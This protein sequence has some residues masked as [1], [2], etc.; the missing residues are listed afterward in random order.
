MSYRSLLQLLFWLVAGLRGAAQTY[1]ASF[2]SVADT[3]TS[4]L[5]PTSPV[6]TKTDMSTKVV[7]A[8]PADIQRLFISFNFVYHATSNPS[9]IPANA[10]IF[11]AKLVLTPI[12]DNP[13]AT[14]IAERV[15]NSWTQTTLTHNIAAGF[16]YV[17]EAGSSVISGRRTFDLTNQIQA[18]VAGTIPNYGWRIRHKTE[19]AITPVCTYHTLESTSGSTFFPK[20]EIQWYIPAQITQVVIDPASTTTATDGNILVQ[21]ENSSGT[22]AYQW[23]NGSAASVTGGTAGSA[24][25]GATSPKLS[26]VSYG[27][28][29]L[30][31]TDALGET[32]YTAFLL[33]VD[34]QQV[35]INFNPG[36]DYIDD[37]VLNSS[38]PAV[39]FGSNVQLNAIN[40]KDGN[41]YSTK[42]L[43]KFKL[44]IHPEMA[45]AEAQLKLTGISKINSA[46]RFNASELLKVTQPWEETGV[47]WSTTPTSVSTT[48]ASIPEMTSATEVKLIETKQFWNSWKLNNAENYGMLMQLLLYDNVTAASQVYHSS[49]GTTIASRPQINFKVRTGPCVTYD[50]AAERGTVNVDISTLT[51][52]TGPFHYKISDQPIQ[53][54]KTIFALYKDSLYGGPLDSTTFFTGPVAAT[55]FTFSN[56]PMNT[57]YLSVFDSRGIRILNQMVAVPEQAQMLTQTGVLQTGTWLKATQALAKAD[58]ALYADEN[59][60][61]SQVEFTPYKISGTQAFGYMDYGTTLTGSSNLKY[62]FSVVGDKAY[63]I[64][65]GV[66]SSTY[67]NIKAGDPLAIRFDNGN[68]Q[69]R[70]NGIQIAQVTLTAAFSFRVA[71]FL[72]VSSLVFVRTRKLKPSPFSI[73]T[74]ILTNPKCDLLTGS[75]NF[76]L[77]SFFQQANQ[78]ITYKIENIQ[79]TPI[80]VL[81][82]QT[83]VALSSTPIT[84][85]MAGPGIYR[86]SGTLNVAPGY[87]FSTLVYLGIETTW[88]QVSGY[89]LTPN[90]YSLTR[91]LPTQLNSFSRALTE[92]IIPEGTAGEG[93]ISFFPQNTQQFGT[94]TTLVSFTSGIG[95]PHAPTSADTWF[96][97]KK[98]PA[99]IYTPPMLMIGINPGNAPASLLYYPYDANLRM[100]VIGNQIFLFINDEPIVLF[101]RPPG[102]LRV[103]FNT[104]GS[105]EGPVHV[106]SSYA[107]APNEVQYAHLKY[108]LDGFY[109][110]MRDGKIRFMFEQEYNSSNLKFNLYNELDEL[111]KTQADFPAVAVTNGPNEITLDVSNNANCIGQKYFYLEVINDK[112]EIS[113]LRFYNDFNGCQP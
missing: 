18:M 51:G 20:L 22:P 39:N 34:C 32:S 26:G 30:R 97:F 96:N 50:A 2:S 42:S 70:I 107:C 71:T 44:W 100:Q 55:N 108:T 106:L 98:V 102:K 45:I 87:P 111:V 85:P 56:L 5:S 1:P 86:I 3:Y 80:T 69:L 29:G 105:N 62:G 31:I 81:Q 90:S 76:K 14:V 9:G 16:S 41:W 40:L 12:T 21:V 74:S 4:S 79:S 59:T 110:V 68:M 83:T 38:N 17:D 57:Y 63:T 6:G 66:T 37:A 113:Y 112:K 64:L 13:A 36:P 109:H 33:G 92:N 54:M 73:R 23:F 88:Q 52:V 99:T 72:D 61:D 95:I 89:T 7:V 28:Y 104:N 91:N 78:T 65:N 60:T 101:A 49:D 11:S 82:P 27:W 53:E 24:I 25:S 43:L 94:G 77:S 67:T 103:K 10:K 75:F 58:L 93:W 8:V 48:R 46:T 19:T 84:A 35:D 15:E 47:S